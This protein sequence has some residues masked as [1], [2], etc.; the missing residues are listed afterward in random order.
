[1]ATAHIN[2]DIARENKVVA[3]SK[4]S[5]G[6]IFSLTIDN[7]INCIPKMRVGK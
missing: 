1:M 5:G 4:R 6:T 2:G 3:D 7:S